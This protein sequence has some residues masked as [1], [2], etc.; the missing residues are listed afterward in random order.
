MVSGGTLAN[1]MKPGFWKKV[2]DGL[3]PP[4][5][6]RRLFAARL[7]EEEET[8]LAGFYGAFAGAG[9]LCFDVGANLGSRVAALRRLGCRVVAVEPQ[10]S[11]LRVLR[12]RFAN[13]AHVVVVGKAAG[14]EAGESVLRVSPDHVLSSMSDEFIGRTKGSGRFAASEWNAKERV[15]VTTLDALITEHGSPRFLKIDVEGF[16]PQVLAGL[17][18][19][20]ETVCFEWTPELPDNAAAAVRRLATLGAYRFNVSWGESLRM[21]RARWMDEREMFEV[22][23]MMAGESYLFG[24]IYATLA[25]EPME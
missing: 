1:K 10:A 19:A 3:M 14:A 4:L 23:E 5:L 6:M 18:G 24:D 2:R 16:E 12:K 20:P 13:D 7:R 8:R 21:S 22:V 25:K 9:D 11:C 17:S 15:A